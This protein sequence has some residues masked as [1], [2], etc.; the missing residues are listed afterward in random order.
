MIRLV[1]DRRRFDVH[2]VVDASQLIDLR[3]VRP[4]DVDNDLRRDGRAVR[5]LNAGHAIAYFQT[6]AVGVPRPDRS[7]YE[8]NDLGA[9]A[10]LAALGFGS[11]LQVVRCE[12][13]VVNV[14]GV[15]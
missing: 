6:R 3:A 7:C 12:L 4:A 1:A 10:E 13:R 5:Q 11:T 8:S 2:R 9:E 15:G 14:A